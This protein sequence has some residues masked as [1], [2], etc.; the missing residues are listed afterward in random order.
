[1]AHRRP[2]AFE[3]Y[4]YSA[5]IVNL[6]WCAG[7]LISTNTIM[8]RSFLL[9]LCVCAHLSLYAQEKTYDYLGTRITLGKQRLKDT[10]W[11]DDPVNDSPRAVV[12][13]ESQPVRINGKRIFFPAI[14]IAPRGTIEEK[15]LANLEAAL[16]MSYFDDGKLE[17][18]FIYYVIVGESGELVYVGQP[19]VFFTPPNHIT[20]D[21]GAYCQKLVPLVTG[22]PTAM[23]NGKKVPYLQKIF[24][25]DYNIWVKGHHISYEKVKK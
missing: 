3:E 14:P 10:A 1:M 15:I 20:T 4:Y 11:I 8:R 18:R 24:L 19:N 23:H 7:L 16:P 13:T 2:K 17:L 9:L 21:F 5:E 22:L 6:Y 25:N 12:S